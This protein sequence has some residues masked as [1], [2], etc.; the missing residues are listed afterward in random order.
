MSQG[1]GKQIVI[2]ACVA[3]SCSSGEIF[4]PQPDHAG[5]HCRNCLMAIAD[6]EHIAVFNQKLMREWDD[7]ASRFA[8]HWRAEMMLTEKVL[9]NIEGE[10]YSNLLERACAVLTTE[11]E[12]LAKDFH[13]VQ[14]ALAA[15]QLIV[16]VEN[17]FPQIVSVAVK[18]VLELALLYYANP[19]VEGDACIQWIKDGA[20]KDPLRRIDVWAESHRGKN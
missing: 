7:H 2:D 9:Q 5:T 10:N 3:S 20:E 15:G 19:A 6:G 11:K 13:L 1:R 16:S 17:R 12:S 4:N 18:A 14:S 8:R